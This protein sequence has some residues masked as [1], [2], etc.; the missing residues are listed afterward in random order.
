MDGGTSLDRLEVHCK[1]EQSVK[2]RRTAKQGDVAS[3]AGG[4]EFVSMG[5]D[6]A[7]ERGQSPRRTRGLSRKERVMGILRRLFGGGASS[8]RLQPEAQVCVTFD[9]ERVRCC[10]PGGKEE[11][12]AWENLDAVLVETTDQG[13]LLPDVFWLLL[14]KDMKSGCVVPQGATG[15]EELLKELQ[16]KLPGFD[17]EALILA[18]A[19]TEN[20]RFLVWQRQES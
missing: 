7:N 9:S 3:A 16:R 8:P 14:S 2:E 10:R 18:M 15:E 5:A 17:H 11:S 1:R 6:G 12:I 4:T 13:P 20:H 19:S